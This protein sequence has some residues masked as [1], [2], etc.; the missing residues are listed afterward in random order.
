MEF[1]LWLA[2]I[3][4]IIYFAP[5]ALG[6]FAM[7]AVGIGAVVLGVGRWLLEYLF[8][9]RGGAKDDIPKTTLGEIPAVI[10]ERRCL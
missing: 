6:F 8:G 2:G 3:G 1:L 9:R 5:I 7:I 10:N 4:M